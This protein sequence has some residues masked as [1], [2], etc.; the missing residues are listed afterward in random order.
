[1]T[2]HEARREL[3]RNVALPYRFINTFIVVVAFSEQVRDAREA[4]FQIKGIGE[5]QKSFVCDVGCQKK[6]QGLRGIVRNV[7]RNEI[8]GPSTR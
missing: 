7:E 1:M 6:A 5:I 4:I 2:P 3:G 8:V